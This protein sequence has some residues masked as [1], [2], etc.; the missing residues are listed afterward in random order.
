MGLGEGLTPLGQSGNP[1]CNGIGSPLLH[2]TEMCQAVSRPQSTVGHRTTHTMRIFDVTIPLEARQYDNTEL[3]IG[4]GWLRRFM[5]ASFQ[6][7]G[8]EMAGRGVALREF[9]SKMACTP[10]ARSL[11]FRLYWLCIASVA[12]SSDIPNGLLLATS[13]AVR[14]WLGEATLGKRD[15]LAEWT[16]RVVSRMI[17]WTLCFMFPWDSD[18]FGDEVPDAILDVNS[19]W[20]LGGRASTEAKSDAHLWRSW[21]Q[22]FFD[23][24]QQFIMRLD[25]GFIAE[26]AAADDASSTGTLE[27]SNVG[28]VPDRTTRLPTGCVWGCRVQR[29]L[30]LPALC[31]R[32]AAVTLPDTSLRSEWSSSLRDVVHATTLFR[33]KRGELD[34]ERAREARKRAFRDTGRCLSRFRQRV[35]TQARH[36]AEV[37]K[38]VV[39]RIPL[40]PSTSLL[41]SLPASEGV[42]TREV[43]FPPKPPNQVVL[44]CSSAVVVE[45]ALS[46]PQDPHPLMRSPISL[47]RQSRIFRTLGERLL[48]E[49]REGGPS[50]G[51]FFTETHD[52]YHASVTTLTSSQASS[53]PPFP[54]IGDDAARPSFS[55]T[56]EPPPR[57]QRLSSRVSFTS[58]AGF[59]SLLLHRDVVE[60][61]RLIQA[62]TFAALAT[63][64]LEQV[65]QDSVSDA[66]ADASLREP[67]RK[68]ALGASPDPCAEAAMARFEVVENAL[69]TVEETKA[70]TRAAA[71]QYRRQVR[72]A[73]ASSRRLRTQVLASSLETNDLANSVAAQSS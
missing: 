4:E 51:T 58:I 9:Q 70:A 41:T 60:T 63:R 36:A 40:L 3:I 48:S 73:Y 39:V 7:V 38:G 21:V 10:E 15:A 2:W 66:F 8:L 27:S 11:F 26:E 37:Q 49:R 42:R 5:A 64:H 43:S 33:R 44:S 14:K 35:L 46:R 71:N 54:G 65:G 20:L 62:R 17:Y 18:G 69:K 25:G 67:A 30:M 24:H 47:S 23:A 56:L 29:Q 6:Q 50:Y 72:A 57:V 61:M 59:S 55:P 13:M 52:P 12:T 53:L 32:R 28:T 31:Q 22:T 16:T 34:A 1:P 45:S 68:D 19:I